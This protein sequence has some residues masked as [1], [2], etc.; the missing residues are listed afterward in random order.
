MTLDE[1]IKHL[2]EVSADKLCVA[3]TVGRGKLKQYLVWLKENTELKRLVHLASSEV[4]RPYPEYK[5]RFEIE[6]EKILGGGDS[7]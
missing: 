7:S 5:Y 3:I 1:A 4:H 2:E 6:A